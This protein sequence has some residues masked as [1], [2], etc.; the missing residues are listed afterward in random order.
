MTEY[1]MISEIFSY[2]RKHGKCTNIAKSRWGSDRWEHKNLIVMLEDDGYTEGVIA[3]G[4]VC[5]TTNKNVKYS[6]GGIDQLLE[7]YKNLELS[8]E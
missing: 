7:V 1:N 5:R 3:S 8:C 2:V 6:R 4:L